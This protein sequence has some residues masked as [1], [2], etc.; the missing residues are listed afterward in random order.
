MRI[1]SSVHDYDIVDIVDIVDMAD[2]GVNNADVVVDI[3]DNADGNY[4]DFHFFD[5]K[6][7][8]RPEKM[9]LKFYKKISKIGL[10]FYQFKNF[11]FYI[12]TSVVIE[13]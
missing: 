9:R 4:H 7:I 8:V 5:E 1:P 3:A 2:V 10:S 13:I 6:P 12:E 11:T